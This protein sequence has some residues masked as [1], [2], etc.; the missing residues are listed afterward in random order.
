MFYRIIRGDMRAGKLI[1]LTTLLFVTAAAMLVSLSAIL[2]VNLTGAIDT[3]MTQAKTP[4]F[5]QMHSGEL[6]RVQLKEFAGHN[7]KVEAYQ[8][9]E[10]VNVENARIIIGGKSLADNVQDNGFSTESS[11]FDYLL[12]L[13]GKV[14]T[15]AVGELY[16]PIAYMKDGTAKTGDTAIIAGKELTVAGFLR[17]SQM[18]SLLAS[19][20]R[21][22]VSENDYTAI[23]SSGSTEYLIEFRLK[24]LSMLGDFKNDYTAAGLEAGGP[25]ITYP[26]FKMLNAMSDGLMIAIILLVSLLVVA[27]A[28][29]CIRFTLLA[30]IERDTREIGVMKAIGLRVSDIKKLYLAKYAGIAA[31]G[32]VLGYALSLVF[33]GLLLD[34]IRLYMGGNEKASLTLLLG[35][36][37]VVLVF[38]AVTGYVNRVLGRFRR[39]SAAE[40]VRFGTTQDK[41]RGAKQLRLSANRLLNTNVFLGVKD[42]LA[43]K[44]L[45]ATMLAVIIIAAFVITVPRNLYNTISAK[46]FI[47]YMGVGNSDLRLDIQQ[48]DNI[49]AR[50]AEV[51]VVMEKDPSISR[52]AVLATESFTALREDGTEERLKIELG[53]HS[54][55]PV[56]YAKGRAPAADHEIALSV[57]NAEELGKQPGDVITLK[58]GGQTLELTVCGTYSDVTN[59]GK[60]AKAAFAS[61]SAD[62]MWSV[63]YAEL[64]DKALV[65]SKAGEYA[66]RFSFAKVSGVD[67]YVTK[68]FGSTIS[69]VG[70]ASRIAIIMMLVISVMVTVLFIQ[71]LVAKD[72]YLIA[73]MKSLGF[74]DADLRVQYFARAAAV[75]VIG[76][77]LGT[78]LANTLGEGLSG[79]LIRSFGAASFK[80]VVDPLA[81]YLLSPLLLAGVV[82]IATI[83]G[84]AG[85]GKIT[86][87][88]YIKE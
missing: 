84:T 88:G 87:S 55:F 83:I 51:A 39:I 23:Q 53:D 16:V 72:R 74:T 82:F 68:T 61:Q 46:S 29:M 50:A 77:V 28:F 48:T 67:E 25:T 80:F 49:A 1:T 47:T 12:G 54:I 2:T 18:N 37:G 65:A 31:L 73:V 3:L 44:S 78:A 13:D 75:L 21:F 76:I 71:L 7:S 4:H 19:S 35:L 6:D 86:I 38:L 9:L 11:K 33:R 57:M 62:V 5:M 30:T 56:K 60:T 42:V 14:I 79:A 69:S 58:T 22:L 10:F 64:E 81:A 20:K 17:D 43:R 59:G 85:T 45:Y 26:L 24:D 27:I 32:C 34:N 40:A 52:Y 70:T 41:S 8:V 66:D 63:I 15:P 36:A